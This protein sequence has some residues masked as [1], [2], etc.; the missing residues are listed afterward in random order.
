M[1]AIGPEPGFRLGEYLK[2]WLAHVGGRV[3]RKTWEGY[4]SLI[5]LYARPAIGDVTLAEL[6]PLQLQQLYSSLLAKNPGAPGPHRQG[7]SGHPPL[8]EPSPPHRGWTHPQGSQGDHYVGERMEMRSLLAEDDL[9][10]PLLQVQAGN[11]VP[12]TGCPRFESS[13]G[14]R[15][16]HRP[17]R[18]SPP[19]APACSRRSTRCAGPVRAT[20]GRRTRRSRP[21]SSGSRTP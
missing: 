10:K 17:A 21:R 11:T 16:R 4:E 15:R 19:S 9:A 7:G 14:H 2:A 5:R 20:S 3:R 18:V 6:H 12:A 13:R 8:P 1:Q